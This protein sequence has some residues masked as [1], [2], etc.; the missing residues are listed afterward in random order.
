[1]T[2]RPVLIC[3]LLLTFTRLEIDASRPSLARF[4]FSQAHMGTRFRI[5]LY[6]TNQEIA[7]QASDAAFERIARLDGIMSDYRE[8]SELMSLCRRAGGPPIRVSNELFRVLT[9]SQQLARQ[10]NGAFDIT[11]GPVVRL[12][13]QARRTKE[14]PDRQRLAQALDLSG[15]DKIH[16]QPK[17]RSVRLS[18][19]GMLLDLG[20]IAK[21]YAA[22]EAIAT[23]KQH[24][25]HSALVA[26]G[27]DIVVSNSPPGTDGWIVGIAPLN[28][29]NKTPTRFLSLH[30]AAVSTSGDAEQHIELNGVRY[31][32]I[33]DPRTG[34][35]LTGQ[36]SVTVVAPNGITADGTDTTV[37][38]LG[39]EPGLR[40]VESID[41]TAAFIMQAAE[42]GALRTFQSKRWRHVRQAKPKVNS[43]LN[44]AIA[45]E[46]RRSSVNS[47]HAKFQQAW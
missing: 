38:V 24:G 47:K 14:L 20:G 31:S 34:L 16:L 44:D 19:P 4:E 23:L 45:V 6:A 35:G 15:Y 25:I 9:K 13:R 10:S 18:K 12:W 39:P 21:G 11:I 1:M 2:H 26:A 28:N 17:T 41:G 8:T 40:L 37:S 43:K 3:L 42:R 32:H 30:N 7:T 29:P 46:G 22:D 27:G 33:V 5:V 36:S